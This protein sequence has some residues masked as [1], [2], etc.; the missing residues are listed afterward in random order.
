MVFPMLTH[1]CN[2]CR[3]YHLLSKEP[4]G[5]VVNVKI[6]RSGF[7][8]S[9]FFNRFRVEKM[10]GV[11]LLY[12]GLHVP[13]VGLADHYCCV[14]SEAAVLSQRDSYMSYLEKIGRAK[15]PATPWQSSTQGKTEIADTINMAHG[16]GI[17]E[18]IL[19]LFSQ[20]GLNMTG[21]EKA[22]DPSID[23]QPV[24]LLRSDIEVQRQLIEA[25]YA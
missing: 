21:R 19:A 20:W 4:K 12:F 10:D 3:N 18:I 16:Q 13:S 7:P 14:I 15:E 2:Q 6:P 22:P 24:A 1:A 11:V 17:G 9:M 5:K 23:A 8:R 25:L